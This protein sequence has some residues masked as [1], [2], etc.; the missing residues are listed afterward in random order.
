MNTISIALSMFSIVLT[1][2]SAI[3][4]FYAFRNGLART[5]N[6]VQERVIDALD[7]EMGILR[8]RLTD[9]ERENKRLSQI[10]SA[11]CQTLKRRGMDVSVEG[12][13][14]TVTDGRTSQTTSFEEG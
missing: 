13:L 10:I 14:I 5:A 3:G 8:A 4:G 2:A 7:M 11:I 6:E 12:N 1:I 9:L